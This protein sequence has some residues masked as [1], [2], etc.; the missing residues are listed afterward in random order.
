MRAQYDEVLCEISQS[1]NG[2][3]RDDVAESTE[4]HYPRDLRL[5]ENAARSLP[6]WMT[7]SKIECEKR[8]KPS[9]KGT[10]ILN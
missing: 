10:W 2:T 3:D 7:G 5:P 1:R 9:R 6:G 4:V 8:M